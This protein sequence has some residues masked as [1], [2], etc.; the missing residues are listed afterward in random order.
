MSHLRNHLI[1][2]VIL[3]AVAGGCGGGDGG[4]A[5]APSTTSTSAP[6]TATTLSFAD[7]QKQAEYPGGRYAVEYD[8]GVCKVQKP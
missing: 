6:T 1:G 5:D 3:V 2:F 8:H 4:P 7:C